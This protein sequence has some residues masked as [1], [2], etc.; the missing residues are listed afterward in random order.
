MTKLRTAREVWDNGL[1]EVV[2]NHDPTKSVRAF[3]VALVNEAIQIVLHENSGTAD[4]VSTK[5]IAALTKL[6][7]DL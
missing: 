6:R 5:I 3:G 4:V 1:R 2:K 7:D